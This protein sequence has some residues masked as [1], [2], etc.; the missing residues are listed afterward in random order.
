[1]YPTKNVMEL[2]PG[3]SIV[4]SRH[5]GKPVLRVITVPF[6]ER[7]AAFLSLAHP[8]KTLYTFREKSHLES[9]SDYG[10]VHLSTSKGVWCISRETQ[11]EYLSADAK[12]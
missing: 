10:M 9:C 11:F 5:H 6:P 4:E 12:E 3:D 7:I 8:G 1:M 2:V